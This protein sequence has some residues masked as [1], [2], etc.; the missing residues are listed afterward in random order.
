MMP[1]SSCQLAAGAVSKICRW[2]RWLIAFAGGH[3]VWAALPPFPAQ[4][5]QDSRPITLVTAAIDSTA[6]FHDLAK[7]CLPLHGLPCFHDC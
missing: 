2:Q 5:A 1:E 3:S 6:F 4:P 7:V